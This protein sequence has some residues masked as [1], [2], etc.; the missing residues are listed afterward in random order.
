[1]R[2]MPWQI[3][4]TDIHRT[5]MFEYGFMIRAFAAGALVAIIA[6]AIGMF[7]VQRR[8]GFFVDTLSHTAL[9]GA[10]LGILAAWNPILSAALFAVVGGILTEHLKRRGKL[11]GDNALALLLYGSLAVAAILLSMARGPQMHLEGLL[12]GSLLTVTVSDLALMCALVAIVGLFLRCTYRKLYAMS[13]DEEWAETTGLPV[14]KLSLMLAGI[15]ALTVAVCMRIVGAL[16]VGALMTVPVIAASKAGKGFKMTMLLS[17]VIS[18]ASVF[19]GMTA[20]YHLSLPSGG[21]IVLVLISSTAVMP[22][23]RKK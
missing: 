8:M 10:A 6:P 22:L 21:A 1:M 3:S 5:P 17:I 12:F 7:L 2:S 9:G 16:L 18:L 14:A 13:L 19:A 20:S 23:L 4:L 11:E 15:A